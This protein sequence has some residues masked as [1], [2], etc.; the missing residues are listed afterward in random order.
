MPTVLGFPTVLVAGYRDPDNLVRRLQQQGYLVL[1]AMDTSE[2]IEIARVHSR[3]IHVMIAEES[4]DSRGLAATLKQY[5]PQMRV[6]FLT[7]FAI[8]GRPELS[9][10]EG[11]LSKIQEILS[12]PSPG[13]P[14]LAD[15]VHGREEGTS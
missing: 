4:V 7:R 9:S 10:I 11:A 5:R 3:P 2:A 1:Q 6:L 12:L 8:P 13:C 14:G 15:A